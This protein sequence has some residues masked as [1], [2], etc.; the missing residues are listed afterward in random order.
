MMSK[1]SNP[2]EVQAQESLG[3]EAPEVRAPRLWTV[4]ELARFMRCSTRHVSNLRNAGLPSI[5]IGHLVR[6]HPRAVAE[7]LGGRSPS[8]ILSIDQEVRR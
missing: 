3:D 4:T 7:W 1:V 8:Q 2:T 6:F 5:K